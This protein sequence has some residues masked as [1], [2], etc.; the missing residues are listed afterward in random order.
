MLSVRPETVHGV[1]TSDDSTITTHTHTEPT[2]TVPSVQ[3]RMRDAGIAHD[4]ITR[5][6]TTG[7][8]RLNGEPITNLDQPAPRPSAITIGLP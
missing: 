8:I 6:F 7:R 2:N 1:D 4:E 5:H 3:A